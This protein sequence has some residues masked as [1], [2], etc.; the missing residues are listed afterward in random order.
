MKNVIF[1]WKR[2]LYDPDT[3]E[4]IE[5]VLN[6]LDYLKNQNIPMV[7]IGKGREDMQVEVDRLQV[8][9]YFKE[10]VFTE[11][12]K[13]LNVFTP[14]VSEENPK[15]TIFI[16]DRVRSELYI[17]NK[18]GATTIWVKQGKFATELPENKDQKPDYTTISLKECSSLM[19]NLI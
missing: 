12:N 8:R 19:K 16:G 4:L 2:T 15:N 14:Y 17:G 13:D 10:I 3:K 9:A 6:L 11:G 1:D 7:L 18:L 5:G